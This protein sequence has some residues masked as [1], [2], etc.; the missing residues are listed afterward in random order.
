MRGVEVCTAAGS[1]AI[2]AGGSLSK[3]VVLE[4]QNHWWPRYL[5][6]TAGL[7]HN[8]QAVMS[9]LAKLDS[10]ESVA[11]RERA[12]EDRPIRQHSSR[13]THLPGMVTCSR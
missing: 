2:S 11:E 4:T 5:S 7:G 3:G 10:K 12:A 1:V 9:M 6:R 13:S 8:R